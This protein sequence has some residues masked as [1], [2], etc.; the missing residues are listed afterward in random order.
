M[1][2]Q[3]LEQYTVTLNWLDRALKET[4]Q[5]HLTKKTHPHEVQSLNKTLSP[6]VWGI[7]QRGYGK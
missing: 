6:A 7:T 4:Y 3:S 2:G 5:L 1:P